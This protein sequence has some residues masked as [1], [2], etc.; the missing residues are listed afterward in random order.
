MSADGRW[1]PRL[2][3]PGGPYSPAKVSESIEA[4]RKA[5]DASTN[6]AS[7][8]TNVGSF[9]VLYIDSCVRVVDEQVCEADTGHGRCVDVTIRPHA[10]R[11]YLL[12][13]GSNTLPIPRSNRATFFDEVPAPLLALNPTVGLGSD[14]RY[15]FYQTL[16]LSTDL[17][18]LGAQIAG[19][20]APAGDTHLRV[21]L[22]ERASLTDGFYGLSGDLALSRE[23]IGELVERL[24]LDTS[25]ILSEEPLGDARLTTR[26]WST[27]G[28]VRLR[29]GAGLVDWLS[30]GSRYRL[31]TSEL[32]GGGSRQTTTEHAGELRALA[33]ARIGGGFQ[34]VGLWG[35]AAF[36][37]GGAASYQRLVGFAGYAQEI[38]IALNQSIG[39]EALV[40]GGTSWGT[41]PEYA[42]F[43]GG[44]S[45]A[46][47]LY[48]A[49]DS[50]ALASL[51]RGPLIRSFGENQ[52]TATS[53]R[54][55]GATSFW[56]ASLN[57]SIPIP[58]WSRPLIPNE[59]LDTIEGPD[60]KPRDVTLKTVLKRQ[61]KQGEQIFR[62]VLTEQGTPPEEA[63]ARAR[64][65][66]RGIQPVVDFIADQANL[67]AVK[68]LLML[69]VA[70]LDAPGQDAPVR[71]A[72]GAGLQLTVVVARLELGY[73]RTVRRV[74]GDDRDNFA[75]RLVFQ[76]L[77]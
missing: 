15:G 59:V 31:A 19:R 61:V 38:P 5:L 11:L 42:R 27:G 54:T 50:L 67:F 26:A 29:L 53:G 55:A 65:T 24:A 46:R 60:G 34:R 21:G 10:L 44:N 20:P 39:V 14:R 22:R 40:G 57:I 25:G 16:G 41:V 68:P 2:E 32:S 49:P 66:W 35:D 4:V 70:G 8:L 52:A 18:S 1:A 30:L 71:V 37:D 73:F 33:D 72:V 76:N 75:F 62:G 7:E 47:F 56:N 3:L 43:F 74:S 17:L 28:A 23:R 6:R 51:P 77:F 69:D 48:E 12:Q 45:S 13:D 58:R 63:A 9:S 64:E 36:P